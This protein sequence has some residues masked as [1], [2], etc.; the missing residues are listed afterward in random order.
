MNGSFDNFPM[1]ENDPEWS[2]FKNVI[3]V[4]WDCGDHYCITPPVIPFERISEKLEEIQILL[5]KARS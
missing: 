4:N 1:F 5:N 2:E 3:A